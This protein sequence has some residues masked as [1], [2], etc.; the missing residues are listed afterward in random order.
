MKTEPR[1]HGLRLSVFYGLSG[2]ILVET[3]GVSTT[4]V[5]YR[6]SNMS[7]RVVRV[8]Q[9]Q[10]CGAPLFHCKQSYQI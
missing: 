5:K 6:H 2:K 7:V 9:P 4:G 1:S 3:D 10:L 8:A